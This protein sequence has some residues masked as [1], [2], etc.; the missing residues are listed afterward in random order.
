[1]A[2]IEPALVLVVEDDPSI[3]ELICESLTDDGFTCAMAGDGQEAVSWAERCRPD[4]V[5]LDIGLPVIDGYGV[6]D[7]L[8]RGHGPVPIIVVTAAGRAADAA[9]RVGAV[10]YLA[11]PFDLRRL[12]D[13]VRQA[14]TA[15]SGPPA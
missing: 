2:G 15:P 6:A 8:R 13:M 10:G 1:M 7:A 14:V 3:R 9:R 4:A 11:K 12:T 5:V